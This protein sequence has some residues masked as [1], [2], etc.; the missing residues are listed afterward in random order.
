MWAQSASIGG[1][2]WAD[3]G[4]RPHNVESGPAWGRLERCWS[5]IGSVQGRLRVASKSSRRLLVDVW[6]VLV[7]SRV[8]RLRSLRSRFGRD[9]GPTLGRPW[10]DVGSTLGRCRVG[11]GRVEVV[12]RSILC[13]SGIDSGSIGG[14]SKADSAST[15][16]KEGPF[17]AP[18]V[19]R[20]SLSGSMLSPSKVAF[21]QM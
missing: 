21:E 10:V 17:G 18:G 4:V 1:P 16:F 13:R 7:L 11:E 9:L 6:T 19:D 20:P 12:S 3:L 2:F 5:C 14:R 8:D 15:R